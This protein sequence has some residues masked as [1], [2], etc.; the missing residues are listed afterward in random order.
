M[1]IVNEHK[2]NNLYIINIQLF[3]IDTEMSRF[4]SYLHFIVL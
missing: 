1:Y 3:S 4:L 2:F